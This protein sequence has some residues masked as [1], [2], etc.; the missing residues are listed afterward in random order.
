MAKQ[1]KKKYVSST[2]QMVGTVMIVAGALLLLITL[3]GNL[4]GAAGSAIRGFFLGAFGLSFYALDAA[5]IALGICVLRGLKPR[6]GAAGIAVIVALG[7][8][9]VLLVHLITIHKMVTIGRF[10][11]AEHISAVYTRADG[12]TFGGVLASLVVYPIATLITPA[13]SYILLALL[14]GALVFAWTGFGVFKREKRSQLTHVAPANPRGARTERRRTPVSP[15]KE[16][17]LFVRNPDHKNPG[18]MSDVGTHSLFVETIHTEPASAPSRPEEVPAPRYTEKGRAVNAAH[19]SLYG[20]PVSMQSEASSPKQNEVR[21]NA[22][23]DAYMPDYITKKNPSASGCEPEFKSYPAVTPTESVSETVQPVAQQPR[24]TI[25]DGESRSKELEDVKRRE[26]KIAEAEQRI[27][28]ET[29]KPAVVARPAPSV[30]QGKILNGEEESERILARKKAQDAAA[31]KL[32][33][34]PQPVREPRAGNFIVAPSP[35]TPPDIQPKQIIGTQ[36]NVPQPPAEIKKGPAPKFADI[37]A[38]DVSPA[39]MEQTP[40]YTVSKSADE[41]PTDGFDFKKVFGMGAASSQPTV[42]EKEEKDEEQP[43]DVLFTTDPVPAPAP[44]AKK[45]FSLFGLLD[46]TTQSTAPAP[47]PKDDILFRDEQ[48]PE[49]EETKQVEPERTALPPIRVAETEEECEAECEDTDELDVMPAEIT[50]E[51]PKAPERDYLPPTAE[52]IRRAVAAN[53]RELAREKLGLDDYFVPDPEQMDTVPV[54]YFRTSG[55]RFR[56]P[57]VDLLHNSSTYTR[58]VTEEEVAR[59]Q[60]L[61]EKLQEFKIQCEVSAICRGPAVSRYELQMA[62]GIS[63]NKVKGH[64]DDIAYALAVSGGVRIEAPVPGKRAVGVEVPNESIGIVSLREI[65]ES[66]ELI[67]HKSQLA[68][69]VGTDVA[70]KKIVCDLA[71]MPHLL[72]AGSTGSGKSSCLNSL[73]ISMIS[74]TSPEDVRMILIDPKRVEFSAYDGLPHMLLNHAITEWGNALNALQWLI[75]EYERRFKIFQSM[76]VRDLAGYNKHPEVQSG[77]REKL[78]YLVVIIDEMAD[79]IF[80]N[81]NEFEDKIRAIS[82]KARAAGVHMVIATQRPSTDVITGTIKTNLSSR[83]AFAVTNYVDSRVILDQ[84][85]AENLLGRGDMLYSPMDKPEPVRV[86]GAFVTDEER[87]NIV[88]YI[89]ANN[90]S[91]FDPRIQ[92][93]IYP[94]EK[95]QEENDINIGG[96]AAQSNDYDP[97]TLQVLWFFIET[98]KSSISSVQRRFRVGFN[99]AA[100]IVDDL[101]VNQF[102]GSDGFSKERTVLISKEEFIA[103]FGQP[104]WQ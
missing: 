66:E 87:D 73:I 63:V 67:N 91:V 50:E 45:D 71:K 35:V 3:L 12:Y 88:D 58:E 90:E 98:G 93:A 75:D 42:P 25:I 29:K 7:V 34:V 48:K 49:Q 24:G 1:A 21:T 82:Q 57:P 68:F 31:A 86:Q 15:T 41:K 2:A 104:D 10:A 101:E 99:R 20:S 85:G 33:A 65:M 56:K 43:A 23:M 78:P 70:G 81:K 36:T 54:S 76:R 39:P 28:E 60:A 61:V 26:A 14:I 62:D 38:H 53:T 46:G 47:A 55:K 11:F 13:A 92:D 59:G 16:E 18:G 102:I 64:A 4:M 5:C 51:A 100:S 95:Q 69:A 74:R 8:T 80:N 103:K 37:T 52:N 27:A 22:P 44:T 30:P 97:L 89:R 6:I 83:I 94:A 77:Q 17:V 40:A 19:G 9:A 79:L 32:A 96:A 72:I 84:G